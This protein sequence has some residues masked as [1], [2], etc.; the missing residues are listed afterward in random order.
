MKKLRVM[1]LM[2][3][4]FVPPE[5][6]TDK[7]DPRMEKVR[8]EYDVKKALLALGHEVKIV[9]VEDEVRPIRQVIEDWKPHV[10]FNLMEAFANKGDWDYYIVSYLN[11]LKVPCT[12]C[13]SRG[14]L[15]SRDKAL[16][17]KLLH[18]HRIKVPEFRV[19]YWGKKI[20][21]GKVKKLPY[22][23]IVKSLTEQGSVAIAQ[24]SFVNNE[25]ELRQRVAQVHEMT[26]DHAIAEQY[27]D[28]REL[29][30][31]VMGNTRLKVMPVRELVFDKVDENKPRIATYQVKWNKEYRKRWGIEYQFARNLP[32]GIPEYIERLAKRIYRIL[33]LSSYARIDLRLSKDGE[34]F[35][36]EANPNAGIARDEDVIFSA[37]KAGLSYEAFIQKILNLAISY[38]VHE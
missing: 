37:K 10:A 29:Y 22:P 31:T 4:E 32:E 21:P 2:H 15:L 16:S 14:M 24:A 1:M 19:F 13:N 27:I 35:V 17:K 25:E 7:N 33:G 11:M 18:Y 34:I 20:K 36:L 9:A 8:T 30:V 3:T 6:L 28:G 12:G 23:M 5:D 26:G 38:N